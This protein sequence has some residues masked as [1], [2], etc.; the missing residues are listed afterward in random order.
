M[1]RNIFNKINIHSGRKRLLWQIILV[2]GAILPVVNGSIYIYEYINTNLS[3]KSL[4]ERI[5]QLDVG[6]SLEFVKSVFGEPFINRPLSESYYLSTPDSSAA[7]KEARS[8]IGNYRESIFIHHAYYLQAISD[9]EGDLVLYSITLRDRALKLPISAIQFEGSKAGFLGRTPFDKICDY[10]ENGF[11]GWNM[12]YSY[13][14]RCYF[15]RGGGYNDYIFSV[16]PYGIWQGRA[17]TGKDGDDL[18]GQ[19]VNLSSADGLISREN[20]DLVLL[21]GQLMPNTITVIGESEHKEELIDYIFFYGPG[22]N[23]DVIYTMP[24]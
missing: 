16:S 18:Y 10:L 21:R 2:L 23:I 14:E 20:P 11:T 13:S 17:K 6:A 3:T 9:S 1:K 24:Q 12:H 8:L 15:G 5:E 7:T 19:L 22:P 4:H